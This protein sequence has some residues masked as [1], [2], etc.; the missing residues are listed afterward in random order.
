MTLPAGPSELKAFIWILAIV[1]GWNTGVKMPVDLLG[2]KRH[3]HN[4]R[5]AKMRHLGYP[6]IRYH[7]I[8]LIEELQLLYMSNHGIVLYPNV[9][10]SLQFISMNKSFGTVVLQSIRFMNL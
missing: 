8:W 6:K 3:C 1:R 7:D 4:Q 2:K 9:T 10:T 5:V